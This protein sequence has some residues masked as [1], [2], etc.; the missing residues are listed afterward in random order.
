MET[1]PDLF[2]LFV[3]YM[4]TVNVYLYALLGS[5]KCYFMH[6]NENTISRH[7][8]LISYLRLYQLLCSYAFD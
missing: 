2:S 7:Y 5:L 4:I 8:Y 6:H 1:S 3:Y